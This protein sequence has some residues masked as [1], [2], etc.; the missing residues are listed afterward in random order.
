[1]SQAAQNLR[2][3]HLRCHRLIR[4]GIADFERQP[5][6]LARQLEFRVCAN[7]VNLAEGASTKQV[8]FIKYGEAGES[9]RVNE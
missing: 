3:L 6:G 2:L 4:R 7:S 8:E 1:V 5:Q 9:E